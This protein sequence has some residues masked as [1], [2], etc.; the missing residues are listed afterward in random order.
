[1]E[2]GNLDL[3][4]V[5]FG[6]NGDCPVRDLRALRSV[7]RPEWNPAGVPTVGSALAIGW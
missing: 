4:F 7:W 1:M 3:Y 5:D 6:D 2:N